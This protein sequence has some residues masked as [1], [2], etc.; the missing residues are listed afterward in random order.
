M[1]KRRK[2]MKMKMKEEYM[3]TKKTKIMFAMMAHSTL[4]IRMRIMLNSI[5][6]YQ[7]GDTMR[8]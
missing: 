5:A 4:I 8:V 1:R 7:M 6:P 3:M 2:K